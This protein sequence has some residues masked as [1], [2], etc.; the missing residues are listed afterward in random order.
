M[1]SPQGIRAGRAFVEIFADDSQLR[2]AL[3]RS[4]ER[5]KTFGKTVGMIGAGITAAGAAVAGPMLAVTRGFM[6]AGDEMDKMATRTGIA[7]E[8]LSLLRFAAE[9]S[10]TSAQTMERGIQRMSRTI[11][12]AAGGSA[13][14][15]RAL[16]ELG[17]E[18]EHLLRLSPDQQFMAV[19]DRIAGIEN[20]T[21]RAA[22]AMQV[23]GRSG[24][25]LVPMLAGGRA[26]I[27]ALIDRGR[28]LRQQM[29]EE[30]REAA[31]ELTDAW[32][33]LTSVWQAAKNVIGA[34]L[35]P[36]LTD[37]TERL[38]KYVVL[39]HDWIDE[40]RELIRT[41]FRVAV[42]VGGIGAA[43]TG[44]GGTIAV[45]GMALGGISTALGVAGALFAKLTALVGALL[46]PIG[47]VAAAVV[48]LAGY[49]LYASGV[50][51]KAIEWLS[52]RFEWLRDVVGRTLGGIFDAIAAGD[53]GL[54]FEVA[55]SG[56]MVVWQTATNK[57]K[58]MWAGVKWWFLSTWDE[59]THGIA[60][61]W[62]RMTTTLRTAFHNVM[63]QVDGMW[64]RTQAGIAEG[65][66]WVIAKATGEGDPA[67]AAQLAREDI[68]GRG[69]RRQEARTG[70]VDQIERERRERLDA[71]DDMREE[72]RRRRQR[73]YEQA[74]SGAEEDL[75]DA[76]ARWEDAVGRARTAREQVEE[77]AAPTLDERIEELGPTM[78]A[79]TA[80]A[81]RGTFSA[82]AAMAMGRGLGHDPM[83]EVAREQNEH[84]DRIEHNTRRGMVFAD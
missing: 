65:L 61:A 3:D 52:E 18:A 79:A 55:W 34:A 57:L 44:L 13:A 66:A 62:I 40:N 22:A 49:L 53:L 9:Q 83:L 8:Q 46:S 25:E 21:L 17:L 64:T 72:S 14:A 29:S 11:A 30:D 38:V 2:R 63:N 78:Q 27:E 36:M 23:F 73:D 28:D 31:R 47:L 54:A 69:R 80:T 75:A 20:P 26:E 4:A 15:A 82:A 12:D 10:G 48:G 42:A 33:S 5:L 41:V 16:G 19:A 51:G 70:Q 67:L 1:A 50:G 7:V 76:T 6:Q 24:A 37:L 59:A 32:H 58:E 81:A 77:A 60:A 68:E 74:V 39:V 84:L 56:V 71:L 35:A 45:A 43:I